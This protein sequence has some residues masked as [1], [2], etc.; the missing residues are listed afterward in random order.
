MRV[1]RRRAWRGRS[2]AGAT[3]AARS[4][5][6]GAA[7]ALAALGALAG[8]SEQGVVRVLDGRMVEGRFIDE[9]AY[10]LY[11]VAAEAE[12]R[13]DHALALRAY[14][15]AAEQDPESP[16]I[17]TRVGAVRCMP[18]ASGRV[19]RAEA[20]E[21]FERAEAR[22]QEYEPLWR[23][24]ARCALAAGHAEEARAFA[25]RAEALDPNRDE[26]V[27]LHAL[28]LEKSGRPQAARRA[29]VAL[30]LR[31]ERSVPAWRALAELARRSG[32]A[33]L[34]E[35]ASSTLARLTRGT[36]LD[37]RPAPPGA[38]AEIDAALLRGD[39]PAARRRAT[40][41]RLAAA[42]LALRAAAL[43]RVEPARAQAELVLGA[44]PA[45][46]AARIALAVAADLAADEATVVRVLRELPPARDASLVSAS[47]LA[48]LLY[49][50]LLQRR[51]GA[52]AARAFLGAEPLETT[53]GDG[54][55]QRVDRRLQARL[56]SPPAVH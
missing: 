5:R 3:P 50:E 45:D 40:V 38:L 46:P 15:A 29:L 4:A 20:E 43:G 51:V 32:D 28:A 35:S 36:A 17:W 18:E 54:L 11:A 53:G 6:C 22:D 33:D 31:H 42:E 44:D 27:V 13:G 7:F 23:E 34:A 26:T 39:L 25:A 10:A 24:R 30:T 12:A 48:R 9:H 1:S 19:A 21:A 8:C 2:H 47:P 41:A 14:E 49:A 52:E 37:P 55:I 16:E 56:G